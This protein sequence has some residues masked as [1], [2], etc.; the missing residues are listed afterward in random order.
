M[1]LF[2]AIHLNA[3]ADVADHEGEWSTDSAF[4]ATV[5]NIVNSLTVQDSGWVRR[6]KTHEVR[7]TSASMTSFEG[8]VSPHLPAQGERPRQSSSKWIPPNCTSR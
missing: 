8:E 3:T 6:T 7:A 4:V 2:E 1:P 5:L